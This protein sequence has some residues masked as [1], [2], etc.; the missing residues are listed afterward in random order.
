MSTHES[1]DASGDDHG[2]EDGTE[3]EAGD[4]G[5]PTSGPAPSAPTG[6]GAA[7][8]P[9]APE[10]EQGV[11]T[12][13]R[14]SVVNQGSDNNRSAGSAPDESRALDSLHGDNSEHVPPSREASRDASMTESSPAREQTET[15]AVK[16]QTQ[17]AVAAAPEDPTATASST[18]A[19]PQTLRSEPDATEAQRVEPIASVS[20]E[21]PTRKGPTAE[22]SPPKG[23]PDLDA[24]EP[25]RSLRDT[26][27]D[28]RRMSAPKRRS[29]SGIPDLEED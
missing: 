13:T 1:G 16:P 5:A 28:S 11:N 18:P 4:G 24:D 15:F 25:A 22:P 26:P 8:T 17:T 27:K 9:Q 23:I 6:G 10:P 20:S 19:Q 21:T 7:A 3:G 14:T 12:D 29:L 2:G